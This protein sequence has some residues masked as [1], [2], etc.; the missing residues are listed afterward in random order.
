MLYAL[1]FTAAFSSRE[2]LICHAH[3]RLY[4]SGG[5]MSKELGLHYTCYHV[6][7][8]HT[9]P[10]LRSGTSESQFAQMYMPPPSPTRLNQF[11]TE[12]FVVSDLVE[13]FDEASKDEAN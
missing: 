12:S 2:R 3:C 10:E 1:I 8:K 13:N 7:D 9:F 11:T 5:K 6:S 4:R